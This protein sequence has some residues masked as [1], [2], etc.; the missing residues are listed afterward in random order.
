MTFRP[1]CDFCQKKSDIYVKNNDQTKITFVVVATSKKLNMNL[2]LDLETNGFLDKDNLVIHCIICKD[3][4]THEVYRY[5][6]DNLHDCLDLLKKAKAL[7]SHNILGFDI[8]VL[9]RY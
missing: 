6:P 9:K 8:Q 3:I 4:E 7:I 2:V 1:K 5:N